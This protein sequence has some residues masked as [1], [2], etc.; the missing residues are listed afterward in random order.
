MAEREVEDA[1]L[2]DD[3][4]E[5]H[6]RALARRRPCGQL[7]AGGV[8]D[9]DD[10]AAGLDPVDAGER[11]DG[12]GDVVERLRVAAAAAQAAVLEVPR[13]PAGRGEVVADPVHQRAVVAVAPEAAVD[14]HGDSRARAVGARQLAELRRV[15]PVGDPFHPLGG[16]AERA[17]RFG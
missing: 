10:P 3:A 11:V 17:H 14:Q 5:R 6:A 15:R 9:G 1:G 4:G 12:G 8:A 16:H 7:A 2:R 13:R